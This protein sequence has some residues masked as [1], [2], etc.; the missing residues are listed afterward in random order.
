MVQK[1]EAHTKQQSQANN[2]LHG[3]SLKMIMERLVE[4]YGWPK[5]GQQIPLKC[6]TNNPTINSSLKLLRR[7]PW[8]RKKVEKLYLQTWFNRKID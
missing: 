2:P 1:K 8:A 6:F 7:T 4:H 3:I 5:L